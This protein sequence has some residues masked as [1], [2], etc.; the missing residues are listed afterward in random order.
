MKLK[1]EESCNKKIGRST[2]EYR[3]KNRFP[4]LFPVIPKL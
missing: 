3:K 1:K 2:K 4:K